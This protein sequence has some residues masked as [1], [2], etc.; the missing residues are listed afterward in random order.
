[1]TGR[2]TTGTR[3]SRSSSGTRPEIAISCRQRGTGTEPSAEAST[4]ADVD[5]LE[6]GL[7]T[8]PEPVH[9]RGVRQRLH[10]VGRH[11]VATR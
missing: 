5:A 3:P 10:V 7:G 6:L 2:S 4:C 1:M 11:E 9:E 8:Q